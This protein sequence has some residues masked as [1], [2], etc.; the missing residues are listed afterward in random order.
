MKGLTDLIFF[1]CCV[2]TAVSMLRWIFRS[3]ECQHKA[4]DYYGRSPYTRLE[5][6]A[7]DGLDVMHCHLQATCRL[8]HQEFE[9]GKLHVHLRH[10][11]NLRDGQRRVELVR[12]SKTPE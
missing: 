5:K 6:G 3:R 1:V 7:V 2:Y 11:A 12:A 8:C 10:V 4:W 9:V